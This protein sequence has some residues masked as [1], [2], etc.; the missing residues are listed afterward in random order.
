LADAL[1]LRALRRDTAIAE[2]N[3]D[4]EFGIRG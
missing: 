2:Q 4:V 3:V 1:E